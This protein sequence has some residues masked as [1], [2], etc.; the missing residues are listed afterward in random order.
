MIS[1]TGCATDGIARTGYAGGGLTLRGT[2]LSVDGE[3]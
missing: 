3:G 1:A 2:K